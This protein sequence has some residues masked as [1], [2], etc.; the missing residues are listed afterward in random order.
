MMNFFCL[1]SRKKQVFPNA[2]SI[3]AVVFSC[4]LGSLVL[5][6][7]GQPLNLVLGAAV[8]A[9]EF[10]DQEL[11]SYVQAAIDLDKLRL[12]T[13][14][15]IE[16]INGEDG[17]PP[18]IVCNDPESLEGLTEDVR[19]LV[20]TFCNDSRTIIEG[21]GLDVSQFNEIRRQYE[22]NP[23]VKEQIDGLF[24]EIRSQQ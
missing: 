18:N 13:R 12:D 11:R 1:R 10:K 16:E 17:V 4:M 3:G 8:Y 9:Q 20:L 19:N 6:F 7:S 14:K 21:K 15:K 2:L 24:K 22:E 5:N 23:A